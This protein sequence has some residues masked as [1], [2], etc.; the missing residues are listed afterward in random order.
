MNNKQRPRYWKSLFFSLT[1]VISMSL[2]G[3]LLVN[4]IYGTA[5]DTAITDEE[6]WSIINLNEEINEKKKAIDELEQK[7][8]VYEKTIQQKTQESES[9]LTQIETMDDQIANTVNE[10]EKTELEIEKNTLEIQRIEG[11]IEKRSEEI[12]EH[13]QRIG[14]FIRIMHRDSHR[15]YLEISLLHNT[16]SDY[17]IREKAV[18]DI[19]REVKNNLNRIQVLKK[20]LEVQELELSTKKKELDEAMTRLESSKLAL[21]QEKQ[22]KEVLFNQAES[23]SE[24]FQSLL[25]EVDQEVSK[26]TSEVGVLEQRFREKLEQE[27]I[28]LEELL[29]EQS[30]FIWPVQPTK[31]ISA[32]FHDP[33][34]P[35]R[36]YFEHNAVDIPTAQGTSVKASADGIVSIARDTNWTTDRSGRKIPAYNYV[37]IIHGQEIS[38]VYGHLSS[39]N[40][41]QE[42]FV[43]KGE[44]IGLSGG[45]PGTAGAGLLTTGAHLHF[46]V[47]VNGIPTDPLNYMP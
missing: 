38:T 20:D 2:V 35:Y 25:N 11:L 29:Q 46:E 34:Y 40:V 33:N 16:F 21:D 13:K 23:E 1:M 26:V 45:I 8:Q 10:I 47:R 36:R 12:D 27:N 43:R 28:N 42:Q 44:V 5:Q 39:V 19:E 22:Y 37:S 9:I 24:R 4:Q 17:F 41:T 6:T 7:T 14:E 32:Y 15:T 30:E 18:K 31:G 3:G